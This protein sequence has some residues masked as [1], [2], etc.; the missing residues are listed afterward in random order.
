MLKVTFCLLHCKALWIKVFVKWQY[1]WLTR[2]RT[3]WKHWS[4]GLKRSK[5]LYKIISPLTNS[6]SR[7]KWIAKCFYYILTLSRS[8]FS[9]FYLGFGEAIELSWHG[10]LV[11]LCRPGKDG[12]PRSSLLS[13]W[14]VCLTPALTTTQSIPLVVYQA[15]NHRAIP[16]IQSTLCFVNAARIGAP[17]LPS[18]PFLLKHD[19]KAHADWSCMPDAPCTTIR[20]CLLSNNHA[21]LV[22]M[23]S[24][25]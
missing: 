13:G 16:D 12:A 5:I 22:P 23:A 24:Y 4:H 10:S 8:Y 19:S 9:L 20:G 17:L 6:F 15:V 14:L 7:Q 11:L 18:L 21:C 1:V 2:A 3:Y 25:R